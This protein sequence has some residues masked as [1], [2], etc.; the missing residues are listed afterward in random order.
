MKRVARLDLGQFFGLMR[1]KNQLSVPRKRFLR[2]KKKT[3]GRFKK[4]S[5][6]SK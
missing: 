5:L 1:E 4:K 6:T 2:A 3:R